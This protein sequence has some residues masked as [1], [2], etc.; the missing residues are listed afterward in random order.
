MIHQ[1]LQEAVANR[2]SPAIREYGLLFVVVFT[3]LLLQR[4][5]GQGADAV[6]NRL[7]RVFGPRLVGA[8]VYTLLAMVAFT[9]GYV[10]IRRVSNLGRGFDWDDRLSLGG[11]AAL[12]L[13]VI[14]YRLHGATSLPV[15]P[16]DIVTVLLHSGVSLGVVAVGYARI[17]GIDLQIATPTRGVVPA[18]G[19]VGLVAV[20]AGLGWVVAVVAA[21]TMPF[22]LTVGKASGSQFSASV[23]LWRVVLPGVLVGGGTGLLY[24]GA[25]QEGLRKQLGPAGAVAASTAL[26]SG[27]F[28]EFRPFRSTDTVATVTGAAV[29]AFLALF[30]AAVAAW[31]VRRLPPIGHGTSTFVVPAGVGAAVVVTSLSIIAATQLSTLLLVSYVATPLVAAAAAVGYEQSRSVWVP[32]LAFSIYFVTADAAVISYA[33]QIVG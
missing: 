18:A 13:F 16:T 11:V 25:I 26:T 23:L 3:S 1:A 2:T 20:C 19:G 12:I 14:T 22:V 29:I 17:R 27:V 32:G 31:V 9:V 4:F 10:A 5:V 28:V 6:G 24:N 15:V 33:A 21:D 8:V 30:A 7:P